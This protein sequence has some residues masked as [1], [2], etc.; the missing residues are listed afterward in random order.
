M[1]RIEEESFCGSSVNLPC[2]WTRKIFLMRGVCR[3]ACGLLN[4]LIKFNLKSQERR[5]NINFT[6][7][8]TLTTQTAKKSTPISI[9]INFLKPRQISTGY[10]AA[11]FMFV[12][13]SK[14]NIERAFL[15][16]QI[17]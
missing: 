6:I 17:Y 5:Q 16:K 9:E 14:I 4:S 7:P 13:I 10:D 3:L 2:L 15:L 8:A 1:I 11:T 12:P